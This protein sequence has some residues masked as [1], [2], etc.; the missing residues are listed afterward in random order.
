MKSLKRFFVLAVLL[1]SV[2]FS[3]I[4]CGPHGK[5]DGLFKDLDNL[6]TSYEKAIEAEDY[7]K[8]EKLEAETEEIDARYNELHET[9]EWT[10]EDDAKF[11]GLAGELAGVILG[12][13]R[14]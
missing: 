11:I 14:Q 2:T 6:I 1:V 7:S 9:E 5:I 13:G 12:L 8:L 10:A 4:S 3:F